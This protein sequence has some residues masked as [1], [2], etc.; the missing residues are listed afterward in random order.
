MIK[1]LL[2]I[3]MTQLS[4]MA[5]ADFES[6]LTATAKTDS[7]LRELR[8]RADK[9]DAEAQFNLSSLY[10]KGQ[11]VEQD[12]VE[13]AKWMQ[14]A[15]EQGHI[16][17]AYNLAMMFNS[18]Q[19][20][21]TD[22]A[23]AAKW[24]QRSAEG[25]F[26]LAQLN[27]GVAYAN[28]EGVQKNDT[29]AVKWF[30][31][32]AE[33]NDAQAQFNLG[34]MYANGQGTEQNLIESYRLS[35]LAAAQGHE[36]A[37]QLISDL[38]RKMTAKQI[39]RANKPIKKKL[40]VV[41]PEKSQ[42]TSNQS[43]TQQTDNKAAQVTDVSPVQQVPAVQTVAAQPV[44]EEAVKSVA[45]LAQ[46]AAA[47]NAQPAQQATQVAA[48]TQEETKF[49]EVAE[50]PAAEEA[51][52]PVIS[53]P[54]ATPSPVLPDAAY[55][56]QIGAFKSKKQ[57][58]DFMEKTRAKQGELDKPY[59]LYSNEGWERIHVGPYASQSEAQQSADALKVKLGY[60]PKV[61]KHD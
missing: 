51:E 58:A 53:A 30:R 55:Y 32:A 43:D 4:P 15:A 2:F 22:Y 7:S 54:A 17:A 46:S 49:A 1:I 39:A 12:Y 38:T 6:D 9:N 60:Q 45:T 41:T 56:V 44:A 33:Q 20:V 21:A 14:R 29:E 35:K 34:V 31:L 27:L 40:P 3:L 57:A 16:L 48:K 61:R 8:I 5:F 36:T 42:I 28:G 59:S 26:A 10:F 37:N 23:A 11:Q 52:K 47:E 13:A 25:G 19:G 50:T 24:Y 18:G